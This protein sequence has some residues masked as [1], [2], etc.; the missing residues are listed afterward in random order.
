MTKI[1]TPKARLYE[2][3]GLNLVLTRQNVI[4]MCRKINFAPEVHIAKKTKNSQFCTWSPHR[5]SW[6][7]AQKWPKSGAV[8]PKVSVNQ[9]KWTGVV[10]PEVSSNE[11]RKSAAVP[12]VLQSEKMNRGRVAGNVLN[13]KKKKAVSPEVSTELIRYFELKS[14]L[15]LKTKR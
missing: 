15:R 3:Y 7:N 12:A 2:N 5:K 1:M 9:K 13:Q 8:S 6:R 4:R 14:Q 10:S 11:K